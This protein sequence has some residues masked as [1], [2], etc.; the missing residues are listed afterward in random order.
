MFVS[1]GLEGMFL[2][3]LT[4]GGIIHLIIRSSC[5]IL[6]NLGTSGPGILLISTSSGY[7]RATCFCQDLYDSILRIRLVHVRRYAYSI[8]QDGA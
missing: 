8:D 3:T 7:D 1:G 5:L 2:P 6:F 4:L